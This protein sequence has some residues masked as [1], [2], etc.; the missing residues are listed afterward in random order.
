VRI[1]GIALLLAGYL[2]LVDD[3]LSFGPLVRV[4]MDQADSTT[5]L[6]R[7]AVRPTLLASLPDT[8]YSVRNDQV[9]G[10]P[11]HGIRIL[12]SLLRSSLWPGTMMLLG[13][14]LLARDSGRRRVAMQERRTGT[15]PWP[16]P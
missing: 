10:L 7:R 6:L 5:V 2:W 11:H 1:V 8:A 15:E 9:R 16:Q 3:Q 4:A 13:G 14:L 12:R